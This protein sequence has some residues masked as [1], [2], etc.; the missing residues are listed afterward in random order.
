VWRGWERICRTPDPGYGR[1][2]GELLL[3]VGSGEANIPIS[4]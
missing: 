2:V 3:R 4:S 1:H